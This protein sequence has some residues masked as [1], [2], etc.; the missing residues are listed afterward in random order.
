MKRVFLLLT[1]A[2]VL[3]ACGKP[4]ES[5]KSRLRKSDRIEIVYYGDANAATNPVLLRTVEEIDGLATMVS[6][7]QAD[8]L[9][10]GYDGKITFKKGDS[11]VFTGDFNIGPDCAHIAFEENGEKQFRKMSNSSIVVLGQLKVANQASKL[12]DLAWFI[13]QWHQ[14]EGPDL[15]SFEEWKRNSPNLYTGRAWTIYQHDTVHVETLELLLENNEI[16][17]IPTVMENNGPVRFKMT[18]LDGKSV[19]FENPEHDFP[20][21]ISYEAK[22]DSMLLAKISGVKDGQEAS[23]EFPL[24]R[25]LK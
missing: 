25:V 14:V 24:R 15:F 9:K 13:G 18:H 11:L 19:L 22:G 7:N 2:A 17:Y 20:Q 3:G 21:K 1:L 16:F 8:P 4:A 12:D 5:F 6:D 23:K 10:C